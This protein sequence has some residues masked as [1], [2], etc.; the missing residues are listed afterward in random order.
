MTTLLVGL[1]IRERGGFNLGGW[2][3]TLSGVLSMKSRRKVV[4]HYNS[5]ID[6][7]LLHG[8]RSDLVEYLKAL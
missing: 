1:F 3:D 8:E 2:F 7:D 6:L 5:C 4:D